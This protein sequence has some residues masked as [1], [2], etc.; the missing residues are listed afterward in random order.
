MA[1][2]AQ[3]AAEAGIT[4]VSLPLVNE[5]TQVCTCMRLAYL[6]HLPLHPILCQAGAAKRCMAA[7]LSIAGTRPRTAPIIHESG[8]VAEWA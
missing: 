1:L 6:D 5:W 2:T 4:V 7:S 3:L 8:L